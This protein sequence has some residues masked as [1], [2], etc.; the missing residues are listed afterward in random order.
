MARLTGVAPI[1]AIALAAG[2]VLTTPGVLVAVGV[3]VAD[4]LA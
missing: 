3:S 1:H 2:H 4:A